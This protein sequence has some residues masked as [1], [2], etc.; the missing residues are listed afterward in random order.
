MTNAAAK[1]EILRRIRDAHRL[2][3]PSETPIPRDYHHE[4]SVNGD[5]LLDLLVDRL[6]DYEATVQ[7]CSQEEA[8]T[9]LASLLDDRGAHTI[10]ASPGLEDS[11]FAKFSGSL[12]RD[13]IADDPRALNDVDA[14]VTGSLVACA[15]TGTIVLQAGERDGRRALSLVPDRHVC[16]VREADIVHRVP[17]MIARIDPQRPATMISGPSATSDI[18]LSRVEGVHGPRDLL[19]M[20]V[21][22]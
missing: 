4:G 17:E 10:V 18:E 22:D 2:A 7:V 19:V 6:N 20:I 12:S 21:R 8:A 1:R 3:P 14:V 11:L 13:D 5:E 15:D 16:L 9:V